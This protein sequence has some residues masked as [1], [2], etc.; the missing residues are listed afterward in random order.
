[1]NK[2]LLHPV[3]FIPHPSSFIPFLSFRR[4]AF[5]LL[6]RLLDAVD[7]VEGLFGQVVVLAVNDLLEGA[8]GVGDLVALAFDACDLPGN[9]D[10]LRKAALTLASPR[11]FQFARRV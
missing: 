2:S 7:L 3:L 4:H 5:G 11:D 9:A 1:M 10:G 6:A 8:Y